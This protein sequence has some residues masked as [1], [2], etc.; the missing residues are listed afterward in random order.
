MA[1]SWF[2]FTLEAAFYVVKYCFEN[3][4]E[5]QNFFNLLENLSLIPGFL[6]M[7]A[8]IDSVSRD[9]IDPR[10]FSIAMLV[11]GADAMLFIVYFNSATLV[12]VPILIVATIGLVFG[13][14]W[15]YFCI[16]IYRNVPKKLKRPALLNII[17]AFLV[18]IMYIIA[19]RYITGLSKTIPSIDRMF[20]AV[21]ALIHAVTFAKYEQLFYVLPFKTQRLVTFGTTNGVSL[22]Q[23][24]WHRPGPLIDEDLFSSMLQGMSM[25]VNESLKKGNVQEIKME[26]GVLLIHQD[27]KHPVASVLVASKSSRVLRDGLAAFNRRFIENFAQHLDKNENIE[28]FNDAKKLVDSCFAFIPVFD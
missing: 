25:L 26:Q 23:H 13:I 16:L 21:G 1:I 12:V 9:A 18:S 20:Q 22:F 27:G 11:L 28:V 15:F 14:A 2:G 19:N 8:L 3:Y 17:G 7:L 4:S 6:G 24:T 10:K 5:E